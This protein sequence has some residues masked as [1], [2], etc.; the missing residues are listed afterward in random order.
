MLGDA[1][2]GDLLISCRDVREMSSSLREMQNLLREM[3]L[4]DH[5]PGPKR[6]KN[7]HQEMQ[8]R[9]ILNLP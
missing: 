7:V 9:E 6:G 2:T 8:M 5:P 3:H 1:S 4:P